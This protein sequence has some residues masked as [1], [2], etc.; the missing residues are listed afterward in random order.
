MPRNREIKLNLT[1]VLHL[2]GSLEEE[3]KSF[4]IRKRI[5]SCKGR[6]HNEDETLV[7]KSPL[8]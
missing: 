8:N 4:F 3:F 5:W 2:I 7:N 1:S 6:C